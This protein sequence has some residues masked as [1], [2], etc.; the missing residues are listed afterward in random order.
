MTRILDLTGRDADRTVTVAAIRALK[1][2]GRQ[3][4]QVS[5]AVCAPPA[6]TPLKR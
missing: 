1:G 6:A 3:Y 5:S 4:M 2:T